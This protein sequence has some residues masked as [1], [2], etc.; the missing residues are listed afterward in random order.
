M[1]DKDK[2]VV[3][4]EDNHFSLVEDKEVDI[5]YAP[6]APYISTHPWSIVDKSLWAKPIGNLITPWAAVGTKNHIKADT[7]WTQGKDIIIACPGLFLVLIV[8]PIITPSIVATNAASF[9]WRDK[10]GSI[11]GWNI[12]QFILAP[13]RIAPVV[14]LII[15]VVIYESS[16]DVYW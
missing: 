15:G 5:L 10:N 13:A 8:S 7:A 2:W 12:N 6:W 16:S 4:I 1:K 14:R 3:V 11:M 9:N